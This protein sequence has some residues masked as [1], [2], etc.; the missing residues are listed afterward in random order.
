[1][2]H[3]AYISTLETDSVREAADLITM[4]ITQDSALHLS[5]SGPTLRSIWFQLRREVY[6]LL[7]TNSEKYKSER[8]LVA[9]TGAPAI[10]ALTAYL[11]SK[12]GLP[13]ASA[14]ALASL[15]LLLPLKMTVNAWCAAVSSNINEPSAAELTTLRQLS[16]K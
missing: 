12:F 3:F 6:E 8:S 15:A 4:A 16:P 11:T 2:T 9:T 14:S 10:A 13:I 5:P 1:M 7:C